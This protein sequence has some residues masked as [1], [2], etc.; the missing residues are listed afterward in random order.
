MARGYLGCR[1]NGPA[2]T[3]LDAKAEIEAAELRIRNGISTA[4]QETA[5]MTGGSYAANIRQRKREIKQM[6]E[7]TG[8]AYADL[9]KNYSG[10]GN[11]SGGNGDAGNRKDGE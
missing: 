8:I 6:E 1:W 7:A 9:Q 4:E 2:R 10:G 11:G 3:N 5:Q